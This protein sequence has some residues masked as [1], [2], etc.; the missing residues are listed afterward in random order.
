MENSGIVTLVV[1][2]SEKR[3]ALK[4][5]QIIPLG[6]FNRKK[7]LQPPRDLS[8]RPGLEDAQKC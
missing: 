7:I 1:G 2:H 3:K 6:H 4:L 5:F 8:L